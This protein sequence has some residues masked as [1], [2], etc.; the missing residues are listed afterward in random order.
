VAAVPER[1]EEEETEEQVARDDDKPEASAPPPPPSEALTEQQRLAR[2]VGT[3]L[4][5]IHGCPCLAME[6]RRFLREAGQNKPWAT[7]V[8]EACARGPEAAAAALVDYVP[9][10]VLAAALEM[11]RRYMD[12]ATGVTD[13][14]DALELART[15]AAPSELLQALTDE[16][17][18]LAPWQL[19]L[20]YLLSLPGTTNPQALVA[21][22]K[23][24][25]ECILP[26]PRYRGE[27]VRRLTDAFARLLRST[28]DAAS[29]AQGSP[30]GHA[31]AS[32]KSGSDPVPPM[33]VGGSE[34][35]PQGG[36]G[37]PVVGIGGGGANPQGLGGGGDAQN[38]DDSEEQPRPPTPPSSLVHDPAARQGGKGGGG[39][40]GAGAGRGAGARW[41]RRTQFDS[42]SDGE[43]VPA[44][45]VPTRP[46]AQPATP[47]PSG[48]I[49]GMSS[50]AKRRASTAT[51]G[52]GSGGNASTNDLGTNAG[53]GL[54]AYALRRMTSQSAS[55]GSPASGPVGAGGARPKAKAGAGSLLSRIH[56]D[57]SWT[58]AGGGAAV[59]SEDEI[60]DI[61]GF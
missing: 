28:D 16:D 59:E 54:S 45:N 60:A 55:G 33:P 57:P 13:S 61:D 11:L 1:V 10:Q 30:S 38:S 15:D 3:L 36:G 14:E 9:A 7:A 23:V 2:K 29:A 35:T 20:R 21:L 32:G 47:S 40:G 26:M 31:G 37:S 22:G 43:D 52:S 46:K 51:G 34:A 42:D 58:G 41:G 4:G 18:D 5:P 24:V 44:R 49:E 8:V 50:Y 48:Q 39:C 27:Q 53:S 6:A 25:A 19:L 17:N 56:A 12:S